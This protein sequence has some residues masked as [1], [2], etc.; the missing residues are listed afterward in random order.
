MVQPE[1]HSEHPVTIE[2]AIEAQSDVRQQEDEPVCGPQGVWWTAHLQQSENGLFYL[3]CSE[4][5]E[6]GTVLINTVEDKKSSYTNKDYKQAL[7]ARKIQNIIGRPSTRTFMKIVE[8]NLLQNCPV[9]KMDIMNAEDILG[10]NV[11][12]LKGKTVRRSGLPVRTAY[13]AVPRGIMA[14]YRDVT[15][16]VDIMF[17]NKIPFLVT[18]SRNIKFG[19]AEV[20]KNRRKNYHESRTKCC[21]DLH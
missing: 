18:I 1:R 2:S 19:T 17:V 14:N 16:C 8:G 5:E 9:T 21:Q 15:L 6:M 12:S 11:G 4:V 20:L 10:P 13:K 7:L 3:D